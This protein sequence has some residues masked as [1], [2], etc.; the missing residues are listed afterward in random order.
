MRRVVA[1]EM[2]L[3]REKEIDCPLFTSLNI[4]IGQFDAEPEET[5][6]GD[7]LDILYDKHVRSFTKNLIKY[8]P[9]VRWMHAQLVVGIAETSRLAIVISQFED[10]GS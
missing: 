4:A 6:P 9:G 3:E 2:A 10:G 5:V 8:V 1:C 7:Q